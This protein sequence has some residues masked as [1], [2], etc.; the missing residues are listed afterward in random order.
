[1]EQLNTLALTQG[2]WPSRKLV[3]PFVIDILEYFWS[4][5]YLMKKG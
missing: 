5:S 1:M 3:V 2:M 4:D